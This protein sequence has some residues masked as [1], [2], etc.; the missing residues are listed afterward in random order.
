MWT[1]S[2]RKKRS[3]YSSSEFS[4]CASDT[5]RRREKLVVR[6]MGHEDIDFAVSMTHLE[7]WLYHSKELERLPRFDPEGSFVYEDRNGA[8]VR[9]P[10]C[11]RASPPNGSS[12]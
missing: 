11:D 5:V 3:R 12:I 1:F 6:I 4:G 9:A 7:G 10:C 8:C 2:R